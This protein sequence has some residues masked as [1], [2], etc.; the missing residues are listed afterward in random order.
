MCVLFS[1][2]APVLQVF[3]VNILYYSSYFSRILTYSSSYFFALTV[4][5]VCL[6]VMK[7]LPFSC[8]SQLLD[9]N[10]HLRNLFHYTLSR[11]VFQDPTS[12]QR[13]VQQGSVTS[14]PAHSA[15]SEL[16]YDLLIFF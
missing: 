2:T 3:E 1:Q 10:I 8:R 6:Y 9:P 7:I 16:T 5:T 11:R 14:R 13:C 4:R 12:S 15:C